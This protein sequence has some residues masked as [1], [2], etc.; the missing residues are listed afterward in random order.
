[1]ASSNASR[2]LRWCTDPG[3]R[4]A[5]A[6]ILR[7]R[8]CRSGYFWVGATWFSEQTVPYSRAKLYARVFKEPFI[9]RVARVAENTQFGEPQRSLIAR[10]WNSL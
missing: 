6:A 2:P 8:C 10:L 3:T 1:M 5:P 7:L 4:L 9:N